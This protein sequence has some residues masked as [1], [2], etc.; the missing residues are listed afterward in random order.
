MSVS[1]R[2]FINRN[3]PELA[4]Y[5]RRSSR[6]Y[7][8]SERSSY[9]DD[10]WI[11]IKSADLDKSEFIVFAGA[12]DKPGKTFKLFKVPTSYLKKNIDKLSMSASGRI[13]IYLHVKDFVDVRHKASLSF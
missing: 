3:F 5:P 11:N 4:K 2:E 8:S 13:Q 9:Y 7:E 10:W 1:S 6:A 12:T